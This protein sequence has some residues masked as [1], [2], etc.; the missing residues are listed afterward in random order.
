MS[1]ETQLMTGKKNRTEPF[2]ERTAASKPLIVIAVGGN[3][4]IRDANAMSMPDQ[5]EA[6]VQTSKQIAAVARNGCRLLVT[7]GNG[8]QV[9][10]VLM[11]S[12]LAKSVLH[13]IPLESCVADTQGAIGYQLEQTLLNEL[14]RLGSARGVAT[15]LTQVVVDRADPAF[16]APSKPIGPF[17]SRKD[18]LAHEKNDGWIMRE[19]AGRGWRRVVASPRPKEIV[20]EQ[21]IRLLIENGLI[22]IAGG[23]GGIPVIR[24]ENGDLRGCAGV[25]DKDFTS[26][27][28][29]TRLKA[30]TL[31]LATQIEKVALNFGK[32]N[33]Q[34]IDSMT[35]SQAQS[36]FEQG[37]F[38]AGSMEPKILAALD[39]LRQGGERAIITRPD[40]LEDAL[41]G[42]TGTHIL[43][44]G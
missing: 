17:C 7:H 30:Q 5:Y 26:S 10:F 15:V 2:A 28:L 36:F 41:A 38:S 3:A 22:V 35:A 42:R 4:L 16:A 24:E 29:A 23:G 12:E 33:Q 13:T 9:G 34:F 6:A 21:T 43:Q 11:R 8:P 31:V 1:V 14:K 39:F 44:D 19:D 20:E 25:I 32:P 18:A 27:L 40:L 37:E